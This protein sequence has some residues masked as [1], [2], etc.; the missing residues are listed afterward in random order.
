MVDH[1]PSGA[2]AM[3]YTV[4]GSLLLAMGGALVAAIKII[5]KDARDR[6]KET[7]IAAAAREKELLESLRRQNDKQAIQAERVQ[8]AVQDTGR[9]VQDCVTQITE[10]RGDMEKFDDRIEKLTEAVN[11]C[12]LKPK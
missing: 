6:E 9:V 8:A 12:N 1:P 3:E 4:L 10:M 5:L 11:K 2:G 7:L